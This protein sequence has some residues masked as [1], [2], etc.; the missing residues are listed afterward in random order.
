MFD[1]VGKYTKAS[2]FADTYENEMISQL[3]NICNHPILRVLEYL[4]CP[5][6]TLENRQ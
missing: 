4:L 2:I 3:Y 6:V 5:I 1:I